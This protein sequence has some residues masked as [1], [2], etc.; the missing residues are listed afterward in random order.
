[1]GTHL[2]FHWLVDAIQMSTHNICFYKSEK[3]TKKHKNIALASL[4]KSLADLFLSV[5]LV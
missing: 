4:D 5:P 1:M 2:N 3:K